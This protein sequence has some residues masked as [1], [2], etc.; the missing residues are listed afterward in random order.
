MGLSLNSDILSLFQ[1]SCNSQTFCSL[2]ST[3]CEKGREKKKRKRKNFEWRLLN[4]LS[5][6]HKLLRRQVAKPFN[7]LFFICSYVFLKQLGSHSEFLLLPFSPSTFS[8]SAPMWFMATHE[9]NWRDKVI[10]GHLMIRHDVLSCPKPGDGTYGRQCENIVIPVWC[11][12]T[13]LVLHTLRTV[14]PKGPSGQCS[15]SLNESYLNSGKTRSHFP[16][17]FFQNLIS[18]YWNIF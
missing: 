2:I 7:T 11:L 5:P 13:H 18:H 16:C 12:E 14:H 1:R 9:I 17:L 3:F 15:S 4:Y 6:H 8:I 10:E